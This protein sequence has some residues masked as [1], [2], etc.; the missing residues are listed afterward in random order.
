VLFSRD[1]NIKQLDG[2]QSDVNQLVNDLRI[3]EEDY[4]NARKKIINEQEIQQ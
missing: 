4:E 2:L 1:E 3:L